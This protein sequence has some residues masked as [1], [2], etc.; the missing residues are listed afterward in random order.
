LEITQR[1]RSVGDVRAG[2]DDIAR[3]PASPA[4]PKRLSVVIS[5]RC[6]AP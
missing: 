5:R 1:P 4:K 3:K 2:S 6:I